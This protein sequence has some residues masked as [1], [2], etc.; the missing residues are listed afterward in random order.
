[1]IDDELRAAIRELL[2]L[3]ETIIPDSLID[4][5]LIGGRVEAGV[6]AEVGPPDYLLRPLPEQEAMRRA[7][8]Y[9]VAAALLGTGAVRDEL[10]V[11]QE[12][13]GQQY[14]VTRSGDVDGWAAELNA[15]AARELAPLLPTGGGIAHFRLARGRRG[16]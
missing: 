10:S 6:L 16:A 4:S 7:V 2:G 14:T 3:D 13:F 11:T 15:A 9:R 1:M 5:P 8:A 12:R